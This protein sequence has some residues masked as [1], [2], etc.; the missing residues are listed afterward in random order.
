MN[1]ME[2]IAV[3]AAETGM[4][5]KAAGEYLNTLTDVVTEG[6]VNDGVVKLGFVT[7]KA[8][9]RAER[10]GRNPQTGEAITIPAKKA[11]TAKFGKVIKDAVNA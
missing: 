6:L 3:I 7:L 5:K 4:S 10:Q 9:D 11:V 8:V 2:I 1:K